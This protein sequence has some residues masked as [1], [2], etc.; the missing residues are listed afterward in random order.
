MLIIKD[1][2]LKVTWRTV[3]R[4]TVRCQGFSR[5]EPQV[6]LRQPV[7][8]CVHLNKL[9]GGKNKGKEGMGKTC[10]KRNDSMIDRESEVRGRDEQR[11]IYVH[12]RLC[13]TLHVHSV[14]SL[15]TPI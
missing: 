8:K 12:V 2:H 10:K 14:V 5:W 15:V 11:S 1:V 13:K 4:V 7:M 3:V 6:K 9:M